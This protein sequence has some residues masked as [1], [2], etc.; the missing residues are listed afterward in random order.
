M[1]KRQQGAFMVQPVG[2]SRKKQVVQGGLLNE[3]IYIKN[4]SL[5]ALLRSQDAQNTP[6]QP[7]ADRQ[8]CARSTE[9]LSCMEHAKSACAPAKIHWTPPHPTP[10]YSHL[11]PH[12]KDAEDTGPPDHGTESRCSRPRG[13]F[14]QPGF[15]CFRLA[16]L[17]FQ[18]LSLGSCFCS[19]QQAT[20]LS[21]PTLMT[22]LLCPVELEN[23]SRPKYNGALPNGDR[24][25]RK[26]RFALY[27]RPKANG[28][29]PSTVHVISTPQA[30]K[31][32]SCKGQHSISY[33]LSRNQTV[34]VEYTHDK[35]TDMFQVGRSTESPIDFVV[36]DTISG[37]QN[38]DEAQITQS[39][40]SR[41][42]CRIVCD[43][44]EPY[45]ARIFA[46]G[47]DSSKNIFLGE[48]AAKW[49]N[50]DGHMDGLTTNGVLV[51]HPRGGFTEESQPGLWREISVCGDVYTLRETRSAQQRGKLVESETN[52]LQD[53]SLIDLCGATLLWRTADGLFHAPTQKHI[54][55]LRQEI[56]AARPQC[57]V[58]LNTL[59]FPSIIRKEVVE[60]K[61]PWAYLS[62]G[63]VHGYH[64][65]GH[66][67]DT[68]ANER[69]CPMCR[70][71]G[72]YVPLW[73]GC[74]AGFYVDA[75]PPTHAFTPC[76]HVCSEKSAKYWSQI[77]LP[78]GTHAFHAAC[79]F[80]ATQLVGEQNCIRLIFQAPVD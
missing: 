68:E 33:T 18:T 80:C 58:G 45:T 69:E 38:S 52:V 7:A 16:K 43:R 20:H 60:E 11:V 51:M 3:R 39:T 53:G 74:E 44:S 36:T 13:A 47:F 62:C 8:V 19:S 56:N 59:A 24:G 30:S 22:I 4:C 63:H 66:R 76:G 71:V 79:P 42:A 64:N 27:K 5:D 28:V 48:K 9:V 32:I 77:P 17:Q 2:V 78:H 29:K 57:P 1:A 75:G 46:A 55:A 37:S 31:A 25:R 23:W 40:I 73:L 61:Q 50:P 35:D 65:W 70:T 15:H 49:K 6:N 21:F 41:F 34:V 12:Y 14:S 10:L 67:S 72:P 26:S 54:E